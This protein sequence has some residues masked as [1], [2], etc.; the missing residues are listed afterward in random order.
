MGSQQGVEIVGIALVSALQ[1]GKAERRGGVFKGVWIKVV[2]DN[3]VEGMDDVQRTSTI[4]T[5][6]LNDTENTAGFSASQWVLGAHQRRV[7][8]SL[9]LPE[10]AARLEVQEA[11]A[12][13]LS[14]MSQSLARRESARIARITLDNDSRLRTAA[15]RKSR[16]SR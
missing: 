1:L 9:D 12:D 5:Q 3:Q 11:A 15:L 14:V 6:T 13:P 2:Q 8:G 16:P 10:E 4:V 7:P